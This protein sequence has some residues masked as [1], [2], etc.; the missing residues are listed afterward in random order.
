MAYADFKAEYPGLDWDAYF[1]AAGITEIEDL[2]VYYP[3]AMSPIIELVASEPLDSWTALMSY[4]LI[5]DS[6]S[7][8]SE[9]IDQEAFHFYSTVLN[10]VPQQRE[11]WERG[12][13]RVGSL[14]SLG[15]AVGQIY[16][17]RHFP[18]SA[19]QQMEDLVENLRS[20]AAPRASRKTTGW[21]RKPRIEAY[22]QAAGVSPQNRLSRRVEG[23]VRQLKSPATICLATRRIS[24]NS[25]IADEISRPG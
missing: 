5:V 18:E 24:A 10:G 4:R 21:A 8:L 3:S 23:S 13:L 14:N 11:R 16:V 7:V 9:E 1:N 22:R 17:Q 20:R 6:A 25:T 19:K 12:V 2:N 15:E